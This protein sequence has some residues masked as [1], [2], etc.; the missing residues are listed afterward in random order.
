MIFMTSI[1]L[2]LSFALVW[3]L[4]LSFL[5]ELTRPD[6]PEFVMHQMQDK[7]GEHHHSAA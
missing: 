1:A 4:L 2:L 3:Y 5:R 7:R 6:M